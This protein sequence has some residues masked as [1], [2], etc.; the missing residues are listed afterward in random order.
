MA[1]IVFLP[2]VA[3]ADGLVYA[4][5]SFGISIKLPPGWKMTSEDTEVGMTSVGF[6]RGYLCARLMFADVPEDEQ[7]KLSSK[8]LLEALVVD[9]G[10]GE[11]GGEII[12]EGRVKI[13]GIWGA[14][15][16]YRDSGE[17]TRGV[18]RIIA[19]TDGYR[20]IVVIFN[21]DGAPSFTKKDRVYMK[22]FLRGIKLLDI[23]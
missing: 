21:H 2:S 4:D 14:E 22:E 10:Y 20:A 7:G 9:M 11:E 15:R 17:E 6:E 23:R 8:E 19:A 1:G 16:T 12:R 5:S 18:C 3:R 13:A